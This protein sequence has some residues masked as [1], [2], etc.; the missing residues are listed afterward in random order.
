M[1]KT[2][3]LSL[4]LALPPLAF[5]A[6]EVVARIVVSDQVTSADTVVIPAVVLDR[7][8]YVA[9]HGEKDGKMVVD[10]PLGVSVLL[11]AG[12]HRNVTIVLKGLQDGMQTIHPMLHFEGNNNETY[13]FP[14]PDAPVTALGQVVMAPMKL[15]RVAAGRP[16]LRVA[17]SDLHLDARGVYVV[18]PE[19]TLA[20][21]G[22]IALHSTG[23]DGK[24]KVLPGAGISEVLLAG[25][26][27]DVKVWLDA[28]VAVNPGDTVWAMLHNDSNGNGL[29]EFPS[30]DGPVLAGSE[31]VM[32]PFQVK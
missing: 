5:A 31:M 18:V 24:M 27:H 22:F 7:P 14:G 30:T 17:T 23:T 16:A 32:A 3:F 10:P 13:D 15:T 2:L 29:Y 8:G 6:S 1:K 12:L 25:M 4:L 11:P 28:G 21:P 26:H 20:Q 19:V 9:V